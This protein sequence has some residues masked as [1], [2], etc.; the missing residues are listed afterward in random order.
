MSQPK[1]KDVALA[2]GVSTAT[3]SHVINKTRYVSEETTVRVLEVMK[4]LNYRPNHAARSLRS[5]KTYTIGFI[6]PVRKEDTSKAFFMSIAEGIE[7]TLRKYGYHVII[8]NSKEDLKHEIEQLQLLNDQITDGIILASTCNEFQKLKEYI[9][10]DHPIVLIDRIPAGNE[11]DSVSIDSYQGVL[12]AM[13][14]LKR[15]GYKRIGYAGADLSISTAKQRLAAY[16]DAQQ[17]EPNVEEIIFIG[18]PTYESGYKLANQM[19]L[20]DLDAVFVANNEVA[21][22]IIYYLRE[23]NISVPEEI[24]V[25][26]FDNFEWTKIV[27]PPLTVVDQPAYEMGIEAANMILDRIQSPDKKVKQT[28]LQPVLTERES[29]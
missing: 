1:I 15:K 5:T 3:V 19:V 22:G 21:T 11:C 23:N 7:E 25:I 9:I 14:Y 27:S 12:D 26:A 8:S 24:A 20:Y 13:K 10:K 28:V 17:N 29:T 2:A 4:Q 18:E 6:I 16:R